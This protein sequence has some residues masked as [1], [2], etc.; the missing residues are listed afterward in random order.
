MANAVGLSYPTL[1]KA[2]AVVHAAREDPGLHEL[3]EQDV[4][5]FRLVHPIHV[6][7]VT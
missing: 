1:A 6:S 4:L 3:V 2:K 5:L 7:P